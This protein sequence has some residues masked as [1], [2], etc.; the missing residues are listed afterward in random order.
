MKKKIIFAS[1]VSFGLLIQSCTKEEDQFINNEAI[2]VSKSTPVE[3][4]PVSSKGQQLNDKVAPWVIYLAAYVVVKVVGELAEGQY[5]STTTTNADGSS[6]NTTS[7]SGVGK[8]A[9]SGSMVSGGDTGEL[10]PL[11]S[12]AA[13]QNYDESFLF[14]GEFIKLNNNNVIFT[15]KPNEQGYD[16]FF[17]GPT[18]ELSRPFVIDNASFLSE[19]GLTENNLTLQGTYNVDSDQNGQYFITVYK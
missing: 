2:P 5:S 17:D 7:C 8:C 4:V 11:S 18:I 10:I 1:L 3:N 9:I 16:E 15:I 6:T 14:N 12:A 19:L 13:V